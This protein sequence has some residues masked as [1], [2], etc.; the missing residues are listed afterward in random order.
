[1]AVGCLPPARSPS[2][3]PSSPGTVLASASAARPRPRRR[4]RLPKPALVHEEPPDRVVLVVSYPLRKQLD[5]PHVDGR[6]PE[7]LVGELAVDRF[8]AAP[9]AGQI[10]GLELPGCFHLTVEARVAVVAVAGAAVA[11]EELGEVRRRA[12]I[13]GYPVTV[14]GQLESLAHGLGKGGVRE[15]VEVYPVAERA[16]HAGQVGRHTTGDVGTVDG[17]PDVNPLASRA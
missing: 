4:S 8:P 9:G 7:G 3:N 17:A 14:D 16:Q 13:A 15:E 1:M 12:R 10:A 6:H 2:A 5:F 11:A